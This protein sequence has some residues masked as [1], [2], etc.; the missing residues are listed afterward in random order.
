MRSCRYYIKLFL[1]QT[2]HCVGSRHRHRYAENGYSTKKSSAK[3]KQGVS[4]AVNLQITKWWTTSF[5]ALLYSNR[6]VGN[7][8]YGTLEQKQTAWNANTTQ[9]F[10]LSKKMSAEV[11]GFYSSS[12][13][14]GLRTIS[15]SGQL[16]LATQ[17]K[18]M[19]S[20]ATVKVA[21]NDV[22]WTNAWYSHSTIDNVYTTTGGWWDNRA[23]M[24]SFSYKFGNL[25]N[26]L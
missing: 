19:A 23:V 25:V 4:V 21:I 5:Y 2:T 1:Y 6:F 20:K 24:V 9:T 15:P 26:R 13:L 8:G 17:R 7:M 3:R 12:T 10:T 14:Y 11:S 18:I 22:F 16:N